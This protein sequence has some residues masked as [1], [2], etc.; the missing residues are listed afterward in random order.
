MPK[1]I[2]AATLGAALVLGLGG[3]VQ[4]AD[5]PTSVSTL[6]DYTNCDAN[7]APKNPD[8]KIAFAQTDLN[9]PWR[10]TELKDFQLW[11]KKLC[12]PNF[13]WNEAGE[14]VAKQLSN[15]GDLLAQKPHVLVL[16]PIADQPLVPAIEM[17]KK[18]GVPMLDIDRKLAVGPGPDTYA[19]VISA[20]NYTVGF[21]ST[22]ALVDKLKADQK[23]DSPKGNI[24]IIMGGVGQD[25]ANERNRG[26]AEAIKPYPGLKI[27][28]TQSGDWTREGGRKVMQAYLQHYAAGELQGIFTASDEEM[29]GARQALEAANRTDLN[30]WFASGDGQLEGIEAVTEGFAVATTQFPPLYGAASLQAA[31]ALSQGVT[32]PATAYALDLKTFSCLTEDDCKKAKAYVAQL[33]ATGLQF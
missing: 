13:I 17:A 29:I 1:S 19:A 33:K 27:V 30:G 12:I 21:A 28:D 3:A 20:D 15:V 18:A 8:L 6:A 32:L 14:D 23:T 31:I 24:A 9:T 16:D 26:V 10:V 4:A 22:T 11:V 25:P 5:A 2:F 7:G